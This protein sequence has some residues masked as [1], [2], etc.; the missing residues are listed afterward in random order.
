MHRILRQQAEKSRSCMTNPRTKRISVRYAGS[1]PHQISVFVKRNQVEIHHQA[2]A[3]ER[4]LVGMVLQSSQGATAQGP[5]KGTTH[6]HRAE[7]TI[8]QNRRCYQLKAINRCK[9]R[10]TRSIAIT[11]AHLAI[12][13]SLNK[14]PD[15]TEEH[16]E[17]SS[18]RIMERYLYL[19]KLINHYWKHWIQEYLHQLTVR[20]KWHKE[21]TPIHVGDIVLVSEDNVSHRK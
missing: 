2:L 10:P 14:L 21:A 4:W 20:N 1:R 19:Q 12:G 9:R 16:L 3:M 18:E 15:A 7:H 5:R 8:G 6:L 17:A 13:R 11:P